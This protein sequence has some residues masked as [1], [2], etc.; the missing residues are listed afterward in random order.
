MPPT[1]QKNWVEGIAVNY[2]IRIDMNFTEEG[3]GQLEMKDIS[4]MNTLNHI[5]IN[6]S[7]A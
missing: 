5:K 1:Q 4:S 2:Q 6:L 7:I 3:G